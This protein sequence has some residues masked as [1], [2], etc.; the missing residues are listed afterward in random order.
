MEEIEKAEG[1][2]KTKH[3]IGVSLEAYDE[4]NALVGKDK[5]FKTI[6]E[7]A[8]DL[9]LFSKLAIKKATEEMIEAK[10]KVDWL[11]MDVDR[12]TDREKT[13]IQEG[14]S[15]R[16]AL[17]VLEDKYGALKFILGISYVVFGLVAAVYWIFYI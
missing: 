16:A 13:L 5:Q 4:V 8:T 1:R 9:I 3:T 14:K 2:K 17:G 15:A 6:K 12:L 10:K 11:Q 7:A